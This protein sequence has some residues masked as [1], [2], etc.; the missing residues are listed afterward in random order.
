MLNTMRMLRQLCVRMSKS[1]AEEV[2]TIRVDEDSRS[3]HAWCQ[4]A[5][6]TDSNAHTAEQ[7][8]K[9]LTE[10]SEQDL[11]DNT[12]LLQS[13]GRIPTYLS[14]RFESATN[15]QVIPPDEGTW[16]SRNW[17]SKRKQNWK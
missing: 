6:S 4:I 17:K 5:P 8:V 10:L 2:D 15:P 14:I 7:G 9:T 1:T 12:N 11:V 16:N 3:E 13:N